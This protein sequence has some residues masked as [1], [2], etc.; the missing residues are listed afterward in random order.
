MENEGNLKNIM[1]NIRRVMCQN[2]NGAG[3]R[4]QGI[5]GSSNNRRNE[6]LRDSENR[7][8]PYIDAHFFRNEY[9]YPP[10]FG[11]RYVSED[12]EINQASLLKQ[13]DS[14]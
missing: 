9:S 6:L 13:L 10:N 8:N 3:N 2:N 11:S 1:L 7:T 4:Y 12:N 5:G 14:L